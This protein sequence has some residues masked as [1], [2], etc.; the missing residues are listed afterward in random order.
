MKARGLG[1]TRCPGGEQ[2]RAWG[3]L[4]GS[5]WINKKRQSEVSAQIE[6]ALHYKGCWSQNG[7]EE[8][9][10]SGFFFSFEIVATWSRLIEQFL[11]WGSPLSDCFPCSSVGKESACN[12]EDLGSI[13]GLG[14]SPGKGNGNPLQYACLENPMD[15][16]VWKV[17]VYGVARV[18]HDWATK[19]THTHLVIISSRFLMPNSP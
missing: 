5:S 2:C 11:V 18:R 10:W 15:T 19:H 12:A 14:G 6:K 9:H 8:A 3:C 16:G 17:T 4:S 7:G 1:R 13:P